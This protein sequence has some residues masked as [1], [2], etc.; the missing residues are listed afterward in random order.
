MA[1]IGYSPATRIFE[2][3]GAGACIIS[4]A[5]DGIELFLE[6]GREILVAGNGADVARLAATLTPEL[7][8]QIGA[9]ALRRVLREHTYEQRADTVMRLLEALRRAKTRRAVA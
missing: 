7:A 9:R 6:P 1:N 4:D 5:W 2:A 8:H 3:A